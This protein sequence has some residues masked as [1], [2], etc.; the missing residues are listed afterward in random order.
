MICT[1]NQFGVQVI[2]NL[3]SFPSVKAEFPFAAL[4]MAPCFICSGC[5]YFKLREHR[6]QAP[7]HRVNK[8]R[9][10]SAKSSVHERG[11]ESNPLLTCVTLSDGDESQ[12]ANIKCKFH[13]D[14][15]SVY[16]TTLSKRHSN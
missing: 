4:L 11:S 9:F 2:D 5:S 14:H 12:G 10:D 16:R 1:V 15:V 7:S 6:A 13:S 8:A 3:H